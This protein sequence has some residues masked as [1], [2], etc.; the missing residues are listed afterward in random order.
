MRAALLLLTALG[1]AAAPPLD[2]AAEAVRATL[3]RAQQVVVGPAERN[4]K[5]ASLRVLAR[6]LLDARA[7]ARRAIGKEL[8]TRSAEEREEFVELFEEL[9]VR[10]YLQKLLFFRKPEFA[11]GE[12]E[13]Q[14]EVT[15]V[16]TRILSAKDEYFVNYE[17]SR[18]DGRWLAT[19]VVI[20]G[21]SI[22][23]NYRSQFQT[24]LRRQSFEELLA[25]MR[26]TTRRLGAAAP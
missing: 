12:A 1:F 23:R 4:E 6:E 19:D 22:T 14:G 25:R 16:T 11:Y 21:I 26:R 18:R 5:L 7:M 24:I 17:M 13:P 15:I 20:E 9:I 3:S 10:A 2:D 8:A